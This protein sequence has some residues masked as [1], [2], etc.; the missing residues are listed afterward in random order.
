MSRDGRQEDPR[1]ILLV[2]GAAKRSQLR[3]FGVAGTWAARMV[4]R[5]AITYGIMVPRLGDEGSV[6]LR[7]R[8]IRGA[9]FCTVAAD[10]DPVGFG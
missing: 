2:W 5:A 8:H 10:Q 7:A 1:Y 4:D 9:T 3:G 6:R